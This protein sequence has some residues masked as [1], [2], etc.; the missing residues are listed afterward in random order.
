MYL[1]LNLITMPSSTIKKQA[2]K[3]NITTK[4]KPK[5]AGN[6]KKHFGRLKLGLDGIE[7]QK[8]VRSEW[9]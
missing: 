2:K 3:K 5:G 1:D 9:D 4:A 6:L 7:F 8:R